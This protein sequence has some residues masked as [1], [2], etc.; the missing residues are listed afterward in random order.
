MN[1]IEI[2]ITKREAVG[3]SF[4]RSIELAF[5]QSLE[6]LFQALKKVEELEAEKVELI[7]QLEEAKR[8][9]ANSPITSGVDSGNLGIG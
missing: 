7:K 4:L 1:E 6:R 2:E 8:D 9:T 3:T 5:T